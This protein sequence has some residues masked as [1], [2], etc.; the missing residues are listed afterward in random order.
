MSKKLL[1]FLCTALMAV[2]C[3][4]VNAQATSGSCGDNA[5]WSYESTTLTISGTGE[6]NDYAYGEAPWFDD[7]AETM[8]SLIIEEG[9]TSIGNNAFAGCE[10]LNSVQ[11]PASGFTSIGDYAFSGAKVKYPN[12]PRTLTY[13]GTSAFAG[14]QARG[15]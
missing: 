14:S 9:I 15:V 12:L 10:K 4:S 5:T 8:T 2:V 13:L 7:Y 6:M 11:Y 3:M 1:K